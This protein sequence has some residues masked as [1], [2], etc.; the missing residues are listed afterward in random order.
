MEVKVAVAYTLDEAYRQTDRGEIKVEGSIVVVDSLTND[1]RGTRSR[2]SVTP[3]LLVRLVN[4]LRR[5]LMAAGAVAVVICQLKPMEVAD[6]TPFNEFLDQYL[7]GE[8]DRGRDGFG[9]RTQIR[10]EFLKADGYH[11]KP[12][13]GSVIT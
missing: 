9:C 5:R 7:R 11:V 4:K 12:E 6:V 2:P 13:F 1:V 3:Q 10:L 8:R